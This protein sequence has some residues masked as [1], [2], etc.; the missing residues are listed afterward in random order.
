MSPQQI[1]ISDKV[2][3]QYKG[4]WHKLSVTVR[5]DDG[6]EQGQ[7][8]S[9]VQSTVSLW[10]K[11]FQ[12][13]TTGFRGWTMTSPCE[14]LLIEPSA[15]DP[16]VTVWNMSNEASLTVHSS[17]DGG[18]AIMTFFA[19]QDA[20]AAMKQ[21]APDMFNLSTPSAGN[22]S[23]TT[24][25]NVTPIPQAPVVF[26]AWSRPTIE[27]LAAGLIA[28]E[29]GKTD[30]PNYDKQAKLETSPYNWNAI[31]FDKKIKY[32]AYP[33]TGDIVVKEFDGVTS[34]GVETVANSTIWVKDR[35][36]EHNYD[37]VAITNKLG[38]EGKP[39]PVDTTGNIES[40]YI[41]MKL[42]KLG[43]DSEGN[44]VRYQNFYGFFN[45]PEQS[46]LAATGTEDTSG[47]EWLDNQIAKQQSNSQPPVDND[48]IPF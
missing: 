3:I 9:L 44:P 18:S 43:A 41:V 27:G 46:Q 1:A 39:L 47:K 30:N 23:V 25:S 13:A 37:W 4:N 8:V 14:Q 32:V 10:C 48:D 16:Y 12:A 22:Q 24:P 20:I 6:I 31:G 19:Y 21:A 17:S 29:S 2:Q 36:G 26:K 42:G 11:A 40:D 7:L 28:I 15:G 35:G 34:I 33:I 5:Y 45:A 38:V